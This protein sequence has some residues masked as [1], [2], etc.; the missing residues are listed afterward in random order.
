MPA[1]DD[2]RYEPDKIEA[3]A[4]VGLRITWQDGHVSQWDLSAIRTACPCAHCND[5][6]D[7]GETVY[8]RPGAPET[9]DVLD[10]KP[11][12]A[13]GISFHWNDEHETGIYAWRLLRDRCPCAFCT[14]ER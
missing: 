9:L 5:L 11:V 7:R 2:P 8:P 3:N 6:R 1:Q 14:G 10:A 12:G 4:A 13:Y